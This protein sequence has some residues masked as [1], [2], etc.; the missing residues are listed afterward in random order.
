MSPKALTAAVVTIT[1][2]GKASKIAGNISWT[3]STLLKIGILIFPSDNG[4]KVK[5]HL[6]HH[7]GGNPTASSL[8]EGPKITESSE[9]RRRKSERPKERGEGTRRSCGRRGGRGRR[10]LIDTERSYKPPAP[11]RA[12]AK[13]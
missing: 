9:G 7:H 13:Y 2:K 8:P 3:N 11:S 1:G 12:D 4:P 5:Y 6:V 10:H